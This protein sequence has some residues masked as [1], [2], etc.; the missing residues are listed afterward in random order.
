MIKNTTIKSRHNM[1]K[2]YKK[3]NELQL[4][5]LKYEVRSVRTSFM[6]RTTI[7]PQFFFYKKNIII[8]IVLILV[9]LFYKITFCF[10]LIISLILLRVILYSQTFFITFLQTV[11]V[12]NFYW[13]TCEPTTYIIFLLTNNHLSHRI[14]LKK[15]L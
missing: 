5:G 2:L 6:D 14:L 9:I 10:S 1:L 4:I 8:Y 7:A 3:N 15:N 12:T 13:F 11:L